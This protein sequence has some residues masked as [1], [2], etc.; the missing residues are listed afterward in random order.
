MARKIQSMFLLLWILAVLPVTVFAQGFDYNKKGSISLTMTANGG[1][2]PMEGAGFS[3]YH[4]ATVGINTNDKLNYIYTEEFE[5]CG[6]ALDDANLVTTLNTF[7]SG[8][9]P[10]S[11]IVTDAQGKAKCSN[12]PLGLYF[13]KQTGAVEGFAICDPF[14][15]TIPQETDEG[16]VYNVNATPKTDV[17]KL[18]DITVKKVW[19]EDKNSTLPSSVTVQLLRNGTVVETATLNKQNNWQITYAD[20]P[21]SDGYSIK[22]V[23]VPKGFTAT[24]TKKGYEFTVTNTSSL[25]Q[26]GQLIW[27]IPVLAMA[28]LF[29]LLMGF[30]IVRKSE[31]NHA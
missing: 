14:L 5:D 20:L 9:V 29:F 11:Y 24:Y 23:N 26:T 30:A 17:I 31:N 27:P 7:A 3:I 15:V 2:D 1:A 22:E 21:E 28:G 8:E 4:V 10:V 6:V 19:N 16:Y 12:L 13:V 18:A 25:A